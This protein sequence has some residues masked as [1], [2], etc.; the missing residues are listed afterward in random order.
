MISKHHELFGR[1][2][3]G[4]SIASGT[5][6]S[7]YRVIGP[8]GAGGMGEVYKAHDNRLER[9]IALKILPP[10]VVRN[11]ERLRRFM[12]EARSASSLNH[13]HIV[14]IHEIGET[15]I[16]LTEG[17]GQSPAIHYI[18][19][20][21]I[22]G[23]TL[24]RKI[25]EE[26]ADLRS[27]L[28]YLAQAAD[29]LAKAHEVGIIHRDLKPDNIM[30]TR[31]GFA[32]VL[33]FGLAKLSVKKGLAEATPSQAT[34]VRDE[35]REGTLL[36]TVAYMSP[37][38]VQGKNT[39]QRSDIFS[40]G[41][42]VYEAATRRRAFDAD[43]DV[44]V[45]HKILREKPV[46]VDEIDG[47]VPVEVRRM[48]RRCL[49][50]DP[51]RR[52]QSMKDLAIELRE[53]VDEFD[54]L[55]ASSS[56][57]SGS[58]SE[59]IRAAA[60]ARRPLTQ[61]LVA[62]VV[63]LTIASIALILYQRKQAQG[64]RSDL[65]HFASMTMQHLTRSGNV[66]YAAISPDARYVAYASR[67]AE[68][69]HELLVRQIAADTD[70]PL[71]E[72]GTRITGITFSLDGDYIY[73]NREEDDAVPSSSSLYQI[74]VMGGAPR[75]LM[76]DVPQRVTFSPD[77]KRMA[78][79]RGT[80][81]EAEPSDLV[82][83]NADGSSPKRLP[84]LRL[85]KNGRSAWSPDGSKIALTKWIPGNSGSRGGV[86]FVEIDPNTGNEREIASEEW[87]WAEFAW[88]PAGDGLLIAGHTV[89]GEHR[90]QLWFQPYP[91]GQPV[92]FTN[93][94]NNYESISLS[95]DGKHA[96]VTIGDTGNS[97]ALELTDPF[98]PSPAL[99]LITDARR[100]ISSVA[101]SAS[102]AIVITWGGDVAILDEP[103]SRPTLLTSDRQSWWPSIS[104][105]GKTIV[106]ESDDQKRNETKIYVMNTDTAEIRHLVGPNAS[107]PRISPDAKTVVYFSDD[108]LWKVP[109]SGGTAVRLTRDEES[110][111]PFSPA[112]SNDSTRIAYL[113]KKWEGRTLRQYL[114]IQPLEGGAP[115]VEKPWT[116]GGR[117]SW[118]PGD[119]GV[120]FKS[121]GQPENLYLD[122]L[123]G[124][125]PR[126]V[127][128]YTSGSIY[129]YDWTADGKLLIIR[130]GRRG[131]V[132]LITG[133]Q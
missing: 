96:A 133:L 21:L 112:I 117:L 16:A 26:R 28:G 75:K 62:I 131:D 6:L 122:R 67:N 36:G 99:K 43:S 115:T 24:K 105:D 85:P 52:Y 129:S 114:R 12:Q 77:G 51:E 95:L 132:L 13:P 80:S 104:A 79:V 71:T 107:F 97:G 118:M 39:D 93:D 81:N 125:E 102:G 108:K 68:G 4:L 14:T 47:E 40:F 54:E 124:S 87:C 17:D 15:S 46:P 64:T 57:S 3:M 37:E 5:D 22:D 101:S 88:R 73:Y 113:Y 50:K 44:E 29:G 55:G 7:H 126:Q 1:S 128:S 90:S 106:Y 41:A 34:A 18:A 11:E 30:V 56:R 69:K 10:S 78:F 116:R 61:A 98:N 23:V 20:E 9:T 127:T 70:I 2:T 74:P 33:D 35:T 121:D 120:S 86:R 27:L 84:L 59:P 19:M 119:E 94:I 31:D 109:T 63:I 8:L 123:D 38:Q 65:P 76:L 130:G 72:P 58:L 60:S 110:P 82:V 111:T 53:I 100:R 66:T 92:R 49:A 32:K 45:M 42:I 83:A 48:I 25:H 103:Q 91:S 89:A